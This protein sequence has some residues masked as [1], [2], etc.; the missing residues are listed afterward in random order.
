ME[1]IF[2]IL[3]LFAAAAAASSHFGLLPPRPAHPFG[4]PI[5][6]C[7]PPTNSPPGIFGPLLP[8]HPGGH[9]GLGQGLGNPS[10]SPVHDFGG[11]VDRQ[12]PPT[13]FSTPTQTRE[14]SSAGFS[15]G[16][17]PSGSR[18]SVDIERLSPT[19]T[20]STPTK[21]PTIFLTELQQNSEKE[22]S[23]SRAANLFQP[24][25]DVDKK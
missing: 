24:Y 2:F 8:P 21:K 7:R 22:K 11:M 9:P 1:R 12:S 25:L 23:S 3:G 10:R 16:D 4:G 15:R 17:S 20:T 14:A 5:P 13:F 19:T 6:P 18:A